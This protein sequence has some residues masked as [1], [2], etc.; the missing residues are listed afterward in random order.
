MSAMITGI[1]VVVSEVKTLYIENT[2]RLKHVFNIQRFLFSVTD[3][4]LLSQTIK[5]FTGDRDVQKKRG[6]MNEKRS[7][8]DR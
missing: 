5:R 7:G 6:C 8:N 4:F 3:R 1:P 2:K